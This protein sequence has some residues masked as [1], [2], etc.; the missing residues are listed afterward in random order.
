M[1]LWDWGNKISYYQPACR[2]RTK[3]WEVVVG[4]WCLEPDYVNQQTRTTSTMFSSGL[5]FY[6]HKNV[7]TI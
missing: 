5:G 3:Q 7:Q 4:G 1:F 6:K 2:R